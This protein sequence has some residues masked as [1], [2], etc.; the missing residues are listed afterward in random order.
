MKKRYKNPPIEEAVVEFLF[1]PGQEWD[2]T[3]PGKLH[4]HPDIK[5]QYPGKPRTKKLIKESAFQSGPDQVNL[6]VQ[7]GI[8]RIQLVD[9]D[10]RNLISLGTDVLGVNL[11]R[12]YPDNGWEYFRPRI[13][14]V[15]RAYSEVA[16][17][18]GVKRVGVRYIN[19]I[20]VP[21]KE[22]E[23]G[24]YLQYSAPSAPD[25]PSK[26]AGFISRVEYIYDD[27]PIKLIVTQATV[28]SPEG[29]PTFVADLD[30][31]WEGAEPKSLDTVMEL[32]DD[33]HEREGK[34][35]EAIITDATRNLFN[36]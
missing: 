18:K 4:E 9:N 21:E 35:F 32:V 25:L 22:I 10:G 27:V 20:V 3:I 11:L 24:D 1:V 5:S 26:L 31:I 15:L 34:A 2:L 23:V 12:P 7:E 17:P 29:Q 36:Q 16:Q 6:A 8:S 28:A 19:K 14:T 13:D 30:V 33:L